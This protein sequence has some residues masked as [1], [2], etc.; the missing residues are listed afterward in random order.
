[1]AAQPR[2]K[3]LHTLAFH[4][5]FLHLHQDRNC[6]INTVC[7]IPLPHKWNGIQFFLCRTQKC[8]IKCCGYLNPTL[9]F[10]D[11]KTDNPHNFCHVDFPRHFKYRKRFFIC[12]IQNILSD[13]LN[14]RSNI[15]HNPAGSVAIYF[16]HKPKQR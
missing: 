14:I 10:C 12:K 15:D 5:I 9:L 3:L 11:V 13:F 16:L 1:M 4:C 6:C 8:I 2:I 7:H